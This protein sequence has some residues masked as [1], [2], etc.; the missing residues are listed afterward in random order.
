MKWNSD[1]EKTMNDLMKMKKWTE[2]LHTNKI[3]RHSNRYLN[4]CFHYIC[5]SI[6]LVSSPN[7]SLSNPIVEIANPDWKG[8]ILSF[9]RRDSAWFLLSRALQKE[10]PSS[11]GCF[12]HEILF[13]ASFFKW[14]RKYRRLSVNWSSQFTS[15]DA[16][17]EIEVTVESHNFGTLPCSEI[18]ANS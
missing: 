2:P 6:P 15:A 7:V 14:E 8:L 9:F 3:V 4:I 16:S 13:Q 10:C 11:A 5:S 12:L 18:L 17:T 1:E